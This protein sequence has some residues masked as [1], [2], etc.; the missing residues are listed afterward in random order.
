MGTHPFFDR[1]DMRAFAE[2]IAEFILA[3]AGVVAI[4]YVVFLVF[5]GGLGVSTAQF[6]GRLLGVSG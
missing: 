4:A 5:G 6:I 1:G 2:S 3:I